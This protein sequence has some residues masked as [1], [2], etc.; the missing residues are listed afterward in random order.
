MKLKKNDGCYKMHVFCYLLTVQ[1]FKWL[2]VVC[3]VCVWAPVQG[4][5]REGELNVRR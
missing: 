2:P 3:Q 4:G 1:P 5:R